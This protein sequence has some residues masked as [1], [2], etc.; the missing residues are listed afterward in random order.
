MKLHPASLWIG[1][2]VAQRA[3]SFVQ[4]QLC[5]KQGCGSCISCKNVAAHQH[6]ALTWL[7]PENYY[8]VKQMHELFPKVC[9]TLQPGE[10]H[11]IVIERA[12]LFTIASANSL[13]KS[14]EEPPEGYHYL[15]LAPRVQGILPTIISRCVVEQYASGEPEEHRLVPFFTTY[16][17]SAAQDMMKEIQRERLPEKEVDQ[18]LD[19]VLHHWHTVAK[20]ALVD[21]NTAQYA[22]ASAVVAVVNQARAT[23]PMPGSSKV[24]LKNLYLQMALAL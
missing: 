13:L 4:S 18:V 12:D 9:F 16:S 23:P 3:L 11:F 15:L 22:Q 20:Q 19:A 6:H 17:F 1:H 10:K 7:A 14:L 24:F 2:K 21:D 8:T 5:E